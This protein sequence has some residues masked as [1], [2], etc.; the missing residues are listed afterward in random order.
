MKIEILYFEGCPSYFTALKDLGA[1]LDEE[2]INSQPTL[3]RVGSERDAASLR[4]QGSPTI[5]VNGVD[6]EQPSGA[7]EEYSLS[8]RVYRVHGK[9]LGTPPKEMIRKAIRAAKFTATYL[10]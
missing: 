4:F 10:P 2:G 1:V 6:I 9:L 5:R 7:K 8:C 3:V